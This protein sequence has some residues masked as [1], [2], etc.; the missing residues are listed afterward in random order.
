M[1]GQVLATDIE[2]SELLTAKGMSTLLN[3]SVR[4]VW[5]LSSSGKLP[6]PVHI[7]ASARWRRKEVML[8]IDTL[9]T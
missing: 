5:K 4:Q 9:K 1:R 3:I 6:K 8:F 2:L 7:G